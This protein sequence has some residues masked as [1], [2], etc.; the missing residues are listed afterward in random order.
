[1]YKILLVDSDKSIQLLYAD[2][3]IEEGY[4][5][6]TISDGSQLM[7]M[8]EEMNP[9]LVVMD[10]FLGRY[11]GLDLLQNIRNTYYN[12]PVIIC[13]AHHDFKFDMRSIAADYY[14]VKSSNVIELKSRIRMALEAGEHLLSWK[15][16]GV[17]HGVKSPPVEQMRLHF[18]DT[19]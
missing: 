16:H 6:M 8:I 9:N 3:L 10:I 14:V 7:S 12:L 11:N 17:N 19:L 1:M 18:Q 15:E 5:V 4:E 2:E 13:T